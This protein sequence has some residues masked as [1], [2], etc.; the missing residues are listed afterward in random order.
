MTQTDAEL[1]TLLMELKGNL[2][3]KEAAKLLGMKQS[4]I[5]QVLAGKH[6]LSG[7]GRRF[8]LHLLE[9]ITPTTRPAKPTICLDFDGVI[10]SYVSGWKGS[11]EI[12]DPPV[13]GTREALAA[14]RQAFNV[15]IHSARCNDER[16]YYAVR[17]WL[18][19]Y[20]IPY[21]ELCRQKPAAVMYVD[22]RAVCFHGDWPE[23][24]RAIAAFRWWRDNR[25]GGA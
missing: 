18:K 17:E 11:D 23:T 6:K 16:G 12:P 7:I 25:G 5:S 13:P 15:A 14:L 3:Q 8:I 9:E 19:K 21:D 2:S 1:L 10:H 24:L 4:A 20:E 22:D